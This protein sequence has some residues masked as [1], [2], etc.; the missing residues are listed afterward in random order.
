MKGSVF[1]ITMHLIYVLLDW[2][3]EYV[4]KIAAVLN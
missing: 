2:A 3:V 1:V 4:V